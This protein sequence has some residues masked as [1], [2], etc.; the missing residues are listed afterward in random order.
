[1]QPESAANL[2]GTEMM[3]VP[4]RSA[5]T[6]WPI[7]IVLLNG[8]IDEVAQDRAT[9]GT[10]PVRCS[11]CPTQVTQNIRSAFAAFSR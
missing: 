3:T 11:Q 10:R 4:G 9:A 1:V 2:Y 6:D 8:Y 5:Q 7:G